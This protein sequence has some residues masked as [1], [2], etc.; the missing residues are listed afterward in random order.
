MVITDLKRIQNLISGMNDK[1]LAALMDE[2]T[3]PKEASLTYSESSALL[4]KEP[5]KIVLDD[6]FNKYVR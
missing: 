5:L 3:K 6:L 1:E 2:V 4:T